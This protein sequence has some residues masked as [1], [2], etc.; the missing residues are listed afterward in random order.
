MSFTAVN[1]CRQKRGNT[2]TTVQSVVASAITNSRK[3]TTYCLNTLTNTACVAGVNGNRV[4]KN[5]RK[6]GMEQH[7]ILIK[8]PVFQVNFVN[9]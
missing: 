6:K 4:S 1:I 3:Q 7:P 8:R 5:A 2:P 9:P